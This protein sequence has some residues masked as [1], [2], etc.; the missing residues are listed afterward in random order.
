MLQFFRR[1]KIMMIVL[2]VIILGGGYWYSTR[3]QTSSTAV[4]YT[5][6]PVQRGMLIVSISESGQAIVSNQLDIRPRASAQ[7]IS[8]D[9]AEGQKVGTGAILA[10]LDTTDADKTVRDAELSLQTA[11][12][13]MEKL[14]KPAD[15]NTLMQATDEINQAK[16]VLSD[17]QKPADS[18]DILQARN[19]LAQAQRDLEQANNAGDVQTINT[20]QSTS[21]LYADG[22]NAVSSAFLD[23]TAVMSDIESFRRGD[24]S[25][26][27]HIS[28][29]RSLL[30]VNTSLD[31]FM[32]DYDTLTRLYDTTVQAFQATSRSSG[33]DQIYQ[34]LNS[35]L[36]LTKIMAQT[37]QDAQLTLDAIS[38]R[39]YADEAIAPVI[40]ALI[41]KIRADVST[42]NRDITSLQGAIG[43]IDDAAQTT[44]TDVQK[45]Q[46]TISAAQEKVQERQAALN[47]L[48][49]GPKASDIAT[50][51]ER[52]KEKEAALVKLQQGPDTL[53]L[54]NQELTIQQRMNAL[55]D[56]KVHLSDYVITAPFN[57]IVGKITS[58]VGDPVS[59]STAFTT[60][61]SEQ[62]EAQITLNEIDIASVKLGNQVTL[63]FDALPD[64]SLTGKIIQIDLIG[65]VSQGV[66]SYNARVAFDALETAVRSGM[67]LQ[68]TV[69]TDSS[70]NVLLVPSSAVKTQGTSHYVEVVNQS[71]ID[72]IS[73]SGTSVTT[74]AAPTRKTVV[75]G[76]TND[77]QSEIVSGVNEGELVV[78]QTISGTTATTA[79]T[80]T[81]ASTLRIPGL[82]SGGAAGGFGG[83]ARTGGTTAR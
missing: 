76:K 32:I 22:Y 15:A 41:P 11:Q 10:H 60:L 20:T 82:T 38:Q 12:L 30:R 55:N 83:A 64:L 61:A 69:I 4:Q 70:A 65:T 3:S 8:I 13:A 53:D 45:N 79:R 81:T 44:P 59:G 42:M 16:R 57:G 33:Q 17:L 36:G 66:V 62:L 35:S 48:L 27:D 74:T 26:V 6:A 2:V 18:A 37:L 80:G 52:I 25:P 24:T 54:Q 31:N 39:D 50:A 28:E 21:S 67:S 58:H 19:A 23:I 75:I 68:A 63:T 40:D 46:N 1:H 56:A 47:K 71:I 77:T 72:T 43:K 9:T 14:K 29:F 7:L 51:Q 73:T 49:A 5:L 34:I 78:T